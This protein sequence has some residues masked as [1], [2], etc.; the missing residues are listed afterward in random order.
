MN[1]D[2]KGATFKKVNPVAHFFFL[3]YKQE[4][5]RENSQHLL[6]LSPSDHL[7]NNRKKKFG[8]LCCGR[9]YHENCFYNHKGEHK[10]KRKIKE[11][12]FTVA[13]AVQWEWRTGNLRGKAQPRAG[14]LTCTTGGW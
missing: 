5:L 6:L 14:T 13:V 4:L 8:L 12:V 3:G 7:S 2:L 11:C 9:I 10:E 1:Y